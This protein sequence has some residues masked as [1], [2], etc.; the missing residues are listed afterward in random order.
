MN[1]VIAHVSRQAPVKVLGRKPYKEYFANLYKRQS[2]A[3][4]HFSRFEVRKKCY[5]TLAK[6]FGYMPL[7]HSSVRF[8]PVLYKDPISNFRK[9]YKLLEV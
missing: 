9:K 2:P 4:K 6:E 7:V 8:D 3:Q 5:E 1:F